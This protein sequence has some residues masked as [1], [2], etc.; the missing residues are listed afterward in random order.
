M[1]NWYMHV[2]TNY[3]Q[4]SGRARRA[5]YWNFFLVNLIIMLV[6]EFVLGFMHLGFIAYLYS[7]A[8]LIPSIAVG[9]R[10]LHDTNRSGWWLLIS[11]VPFVGIVVVLVLLAL[12]G[13]PG[14]NQY[15][16]DPKAMAAVATA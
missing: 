15:G 11:L 1:I 14:P 4:F 5:E 9:I 10:R 12:E 7:L 16:P 3:A 13:T 2:L 6:L 8:V